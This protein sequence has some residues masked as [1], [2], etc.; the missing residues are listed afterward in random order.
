MMPRSSLLLLR[1]GI[2]AAF[3]AP[4]SSAAQGRATRS[5]LAGSGTTCQGPDGAFTFRLPKGWRAQAVPL[6]G[7]P[8]MA[9][10]P[11]N[12]GD[13]RIILSATPAKGSIRE[14]AQQ[15]ISFVLQSFP[16]VRPQGSP[17]FSTING[18][19]A[20]ELSYEGDLLNG[21]SLRLWGGALLKNGTC[22][23]VMALGRSEGGAVIERHARALF[24]TIRP[25]RG[26]P[27]PQMARAIVGRWSYYYGSTS[28]IGTSTSSST[29]VSK[30][31]VFH[32]NGRFEYIGGVSTNVE[33]PSDI[34]GHGS[35]DTRSGSTLTARFDSGGQ[36][37]FRVEPVPGGA[38]KI[39]GMLFIRE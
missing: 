14:V 39:N 37:T 16:G 35:G 27:V 25:A 34:G 13:E 1:L 19:P 30:T 3:A 32:P 26:R 36:A 29:S 9:L 18:M 5:Q 38:L 12:G 33:L 10:T 23:G 6:G 17:A 15:G 24:R 8:A 28:G 11:T 20:V 4:P 21:S 22:Y 7:Q 31:V 2:A